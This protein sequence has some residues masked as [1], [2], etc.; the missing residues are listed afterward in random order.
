MM[1]VAVGYRNVIIAF[2]GALWLPGV[3]GRVESAERASAADGVLVSPVYVD[4]SATVDLERAESSFQS[5]DLVGGVTHLRRLLD[6]PIDSFGSGHGRLN[7]VRADAEALLRQQPPGTR[8]FYESAEAAS[9]AAALAGSDGTAVTTLRT[10]VRRFPATE[11]GFHAAD[12]LATIAFDRGDFRTA[13]RQWENLLEDPRYARR[14]RPATIARLLTA[15]RRSGR[16]GRASELSIRYSGMSLR[17]G[18]EPATVGQLLS[19]IRPAVAAI[20]TTAE[21][22][23]SGAGLTPPAFPAVWATGDGVGAEP[24]RELWAGSRRAE[25]RPV[26]VPAGAV[27]TPSGVVVRDAAAVVAYD[28]ESG[29]PLWRMPM[30]GECGPQATSPGDLNEL[31]RLETGYASG[32]VYGRLTA[33][34]ER[35]YVLDSAAEAASSSVRTASHVPVGDVAVPAGV[36]EQQ[37]GGI[38]TNR[39]LALPTSL[40]NDAE[41]RPL[42]VVGGHVGGDARLAGHYFFGPPTVTDDGLLALAEHRQCLYLVALN[43]GTGE[44]LWRQPLGYVP[45]PVASDGARGAA[46]CVPTVAEGVA[47]CCT[48]AGFVV[49]YDAAA[50]RLLW[51]YDYAAGESE[52]GRQDRASDRTA[53][54]GDPAFPCPAVT[55]HHRV[56]F[57]PDDS[58]FVHCVDL[59]TGLNLWKSPRE[60]GL[61]VACVDDRSALIVGRSRCRALSIAGGSLVWA[62]RFGTPAGTGVA[63]DTAYL[64]PLE[65]GRVLGIDLARGCA[66]GFDVP[67]SA[68]GFRPS[69]GEADIVYGARWRP[70]N[71]YTDGENLLSVGPGGVAKLRTASHEIEVSDEAS[72][73]LDRARIELAAGRLEQAATRLE[74]LVAADAEAVDSAE[75]EILLRELHYLRLDATVG[76]TVDPIAELDRLSRTPEERGRFLLRAAERDLGSEDLESLR[77]RTDELAHLDLLGPIASP[78]DATLLVTPTSWVPSLLRRG[79]L[80]GRDLDE[81]PGSLVAWPTPDLER[82]LPFLEDGPEAQEVRLELAGRAV[83][84]GEWQRAELLLLRNLESGDS[85]ASRR[86]LDD[87]RRLAGLPVGEPRRHASE[88]PAGDVQITGRLWAP[89]N[90]GVRRA[91]GGKRRGFPTRGR[92][93][94]RVV[95]R[96]DSRRSRLAVVDLEGG[97]CRGEVAVDSRLRWPLANRQSA[98]G[99]LV[100]V[101]SVGRL[102]G[103][104]LLEIHRGE[105]VWTANLPDA[106]GMLPQVGPYGPSFCTIQTRCELTTLDPAS[107]EVLWQRTELPPELGLHGDQAAG[108][109]GDAETLTMLDSDGSTYATYRT[110]T[111]EELG[112]GRLPIDRQRQRR[113]YGRKLFFVETGD[114]T[115]TARLW[116]PLTNAYELAIGFEGR[117]LQTSTREDELVLLFADGRLLIYDTVASSAAVDV[118]LD[119]PGGAGGVDPHAV[120][121]FS[122]EDRYY[123]SL[124]RPDPTRSDESKV[125]SFIYDMP[126]SAAHVQGRLLAIDRL[127]GAVLWDRSTD[128]RSVIDPVDHPGPFLVATARVSDRRLGNR[129][130]LLV[131]AIDKETGA[132][133]GRNDALMADQP[134]QIRSGV[135]RVELAGMTSTVVLKFDAE[136]LDDAVAVGAR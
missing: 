63:T 111:G 126:L 26:A 125:T 1:R 101:A 18:G 27:V 5:G 104:S 74:T 88:Q 99:H 115:S 16:D 96:G 56:V 97:V 37:P 55:R 29:M 128:Q 90:E 8:Q 23:T 62:A 82:R 136:P 123:V 19:R 102:H 30:S 7:G 65:D 85:V 109:F 67:R 120:W 34:D 52:A 129:K 124:Y 49:A 107:G 110:E 33:D 14:A 79:G 21:P 75:A 47:V 20:P 92:D 119:L 11:P 41:E 91:F 78:V 40:P 66:T 28:A 73:T 45:R 4:R 134:L 39:L 15:L 114:G 13:A 112:T 44:V 86:G 9:A 51:A 10:V 6:Q 25:G 77:R 42:W 3:H 135:D 54:H 100:P 57:M 87:L 122:D 32:G 68:S 116:D 71:L 113:A 60:D 98:R 58:R 81:N 118:R 24:L 2:T 80:G 72:T 93:L 117:L 53:Y 84:D 105:P 12:R 35:V 69:G 103:L 130:T 121:I 59:R 76:G 17:L 94:L 36:A 43:P 38:R 89:A 108:L 64:L 22:D 61:Y 83:A 70:G 106:D 48:N 31:T 50:G 46:A 127:S 133:L 95:D 132:T 131:E